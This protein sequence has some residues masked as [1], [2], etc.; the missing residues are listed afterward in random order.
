M[1]IKIMDN[2][3]RRNLR[4]YDILVSKDGN[5]YIVTKGDLID[6]PYKISNLLTHETKRN[7]K[8]LEKQVTRIGHVLGVGY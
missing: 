5:Y 6:F 2:S 8:T 3:F 7:L 4:L 1:N